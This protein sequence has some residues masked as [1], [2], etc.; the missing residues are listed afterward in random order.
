VHQCARRVFFSCTAALLLVRAAS[1]A[2]PISGPIPP[3][4]MSISVFTENFGPT[5][6][7]GNYW[8]T[9]RFGSLRLWDTHTGWPDLEPSPGVYRWD[10]LNGWL[11]FAQA[12]GLTDILYTF[13][14]TATWAATDPTNVNCKYGP[15]TCTPPSDLDSFGDGTDQMWIDFVR[16]L[17]TVGKGRIKYYQLW[18]T[19]QDPTHWTGQVAQLVRMSQDAYTTI[20][21]IDPT[22]K[23]LSPPS[24]A[25]KA[26]SVCAIANRAQGFFKAGG[27]Q[28]VDVISF[29]TYFDKIAE[30]II[31]V[32]DCFTNQVLIPY[33]QSSKPLWASEGGWGTSAD[34]FDPTL[35]AAFLARSYLVLLSK[36]VRRFYWYSWN[37]PNWGTLWN[38]NTG[39]LVPGRAY[40]QIYSWLIGHTVTQPCAA[41][42]NGLWTCVLTG[43]NGLQ[44][45]AM[46]VQGPTQNYTPP[47][48]YIRYRDLLGG[49]RTIT[50]GQQI[51]ITNSPILLQNQ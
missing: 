32:I 12:H 21:S 9:V 48:Q 26:P 35:Q 49:S 30:D 45:Q 8:P 25:Y 18:D 28:W 16:Q 41:D 37:N 22:V 47:A 19:P 1:A 36:G 50:A 15:G 20:K 33:G 14:S 46:W 5:T 11:T 40:A 29:N 2:T 3:Q 10:L 4:F 6:L 39:I 17:A 13:G 51:A 23:I 43:A 34:L 24:G 27:G 38:K 31:P 42:A 7:P 44:A